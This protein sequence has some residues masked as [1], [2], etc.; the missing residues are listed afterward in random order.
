MGRFFF[1]CECICIDIYGYIDVYVDT[2]REIYV[3]RY[4][5]RYRDI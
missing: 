1:V 4:I 2:Y 3:E 5:E